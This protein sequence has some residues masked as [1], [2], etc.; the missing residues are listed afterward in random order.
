M[1]DLDEQLVR[2]R[3]AQ[4]RLLMAVRL[5]YMVLL[6]TVTLLP[7]VASIKGTQTV[8]FRDYAGA[9]VLTFIFGVAVLVLDAATPSKKLSAVFGIYLGI[10]AGLVGALAIG[11]LLDLIAKSWELEN[12]PWIG[13]S[14]LVKL[15]IGITLCYLAVSIVLTTKDD[16]RLVIP[17]VEFSKQVR[18]TRPLLVDTSTLIDGRIDLLAT[19]GFLD[20]PLVIP[21]FVLHEL[22]LLADSA[23]RLKR[24]R[25][26]RGLDLVR[27]LQANPKIDVSIDPTEAPGHS[28]DHMLIRLA[29]ERNQRIVTTDYNLNKVAQIHGVDVLNLHELAGALRPQI[30]AG[31]RLDVEIQRA[32]EAEGQGVGYLADGTMVVVERARDHIGRTVGAVVTNALQTSAGRMIFAK[33]GEA[34]NGATEAERRAAAMAKAATS[35]PRATERPDE[36]PP[37]SKRNPRR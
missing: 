8:D 9:F 11:L 21:R 29:S 6:M 15:A 30:V 16:F 14:G 34:E 7:F 35:Q 13:K 37:P 2:G 20:A 25:G 31:D 28:V 22:Q 5:L 1:P 17:Y 23:D 27:T 12:S 36:P 24:A 4:K 18:G 33:L 26:R 3:R 19:S 32:G 10:I